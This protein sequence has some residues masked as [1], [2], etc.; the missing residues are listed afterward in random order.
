[1]KNFF[2]IVVFKIVITF[3]A[4]GRK[5]SEQ[6]NILKDKHQPMK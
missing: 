4:D 2:V 3:G 5:S 1:M 6:N